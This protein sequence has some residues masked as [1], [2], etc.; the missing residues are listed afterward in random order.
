[1]RRQPTALA[2]AGLGVDCD[3]ALLAA[4]RRRRLRGGSR[5]HPD[6]APPDRAA[7]ALRDPRSASWTACS[8]SRCSACSTHARR[9]SKAPA[10]APRSWRSKRPRCS[11]ATTRR[12]GRRARRRTSNRSRLVEEARRAHQATVGEAR[13]AAERES[14]ARAARS[15]ARRT[16]VRGSAR[17]RGRTAGAR[18]RR[19]PARPERRVKRDRMLAPA[20]L[21]AARAGARVGVGRGRRSRRRVCSGMRINLALVVGVIVYFARTPIRTYMAER[22]Q[23]IEAGIEA[24]RRELSEAEQPAGRVQRAGRL[25][26][27]RSRR[28]PPH[29]ARAG[30]ERA[31]ATRSPT[32]AP[33]PSG[34]AATRTPPSNRNRAAR[35]RTLRNEAAEMAVRLAADLLKRQVTDSDRA[36]LVDEFVERVESSPP[37]DGDAELS[38]M[39]GKRSAALR[40]AR[41]L[42]GLAQEAGAVESM[43]AELDRCQRGDRRRFRR[44][45]TSSCFRCIPQPSVVQRCKRLAGPL[46]L[47]PLLT[48]FLSFLIDQRRTRDLAAIH[49]DYVRLAEEAAGRVRGE[50]V[51]AT[52]L[53]SAQLERIRAA[54]ARAHGPRTRPRGPRRSRSPRRAGGPGRRP[55]IRRK[56]AHPARAAPRA[57]HGR[58]MSDASRH[59]AG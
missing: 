31:R 26:R 19:T 20:L 14:T 46:G 4:A 35:A 39:A 42:F 55:R 32:P 51:S 3:V 17:R 56:S 22:R 18:N 1:M 15:R 13:T 44:S 6:P 24:A 43:R 50:V 37:A 40:Y 9:A 33:P 28:D 58:T 45:P 38:P 25:A 48:H 29:R 59:Q 11:R 12:C 47:S 49:E 10:S 2:R 27:P 53:D 54:L 34:S 7:R 52:P 5:D 30:R 41:A 23:N 21:R 8:S 57:T 16:S 36:R